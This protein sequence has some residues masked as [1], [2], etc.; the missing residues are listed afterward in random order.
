M[1][2]RARRSRRGLIKIAYP[3]ALG[4]EWREPIIDAA[5]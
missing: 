2:E 1:I 3:E 4:T 5:W